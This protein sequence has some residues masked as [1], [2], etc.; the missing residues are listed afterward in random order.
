MT[1]K[2]YIFTAFF[3][4]QD[5]MG[6]WSPKCIL[7]RDLRTVVLSEASNPNI[8]LPKT[9]TL[10]HYFR[11]KVYHLRSSF[12]TETEWGEW[13]PKSILTRDLRTVAPSEASNPN[14]LLQ[15]QSRSIFQ[16]ETEWVSEVWKCTL[17]RDLK[18]AV[19]SEASTS[20]AGTCNIGMR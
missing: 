12:Q 20:I 14:V 3:K 9:E 1:A 6:E 11:A 13:G 5:W 10:I 15:G 18:I 7:T 19:P 16:T 4:N 2:T 8:L 17:N